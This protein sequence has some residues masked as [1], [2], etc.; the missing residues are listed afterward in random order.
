MYTY[1]SSTVIQFQ[2]SHK[3]A[4]FKVVAYTYNWNFIFVLIIET[5]E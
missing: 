4:A 3:I 5:R 1:T 2:V